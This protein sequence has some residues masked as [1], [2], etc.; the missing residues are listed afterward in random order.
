[1]YNFKILASLCQCFQQNVKVACDGI[2]WAWLISIA[3]CGYKHILLQIRA[4]LKGRG[5]GAIFAGEPL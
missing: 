1:M 4:G 2:S 3:A 5:A